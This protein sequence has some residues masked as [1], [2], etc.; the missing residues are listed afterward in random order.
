MLSHVVTVASVGVT[1]SA[2]I[3]QAP[4]VTLVDKV[5]G[6]TQRDIVVLSAVARNVWSADT[7][8]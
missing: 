1:S 5:I 4:A 3:V 7:Q 2:A 8:L 6:I